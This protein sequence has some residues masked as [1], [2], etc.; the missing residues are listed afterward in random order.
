MG[1]PELPLSGSSGCEA[2]AERPRGRARK[3]AARVVSASRRTELLG[4]Y[5]DLFASRLE[6][7]GAE[8]V[9]SVVIWTKD[10]SNLLSHARLCRALAG[11]GQVF[12]HWTVTGL[13]GTFLESHVSP[14]EA[15]LALLPRVVDYVGDPR[16][17]HWRY[18]PLI[19]V[20]RG[21]EAIT[22]LD[23]DRFRALA[24]DFAR[25]G[26]PAVHTSFL[27]PYPKVTRRLEAAGV[28]L[29][30][31]GADEQLAFLGQVSQEAQDLGLELITCA[32]PGFP[33]R[34]CIDGE[35][36]TAL[37]PAGMACRTDRARGQRELCGCT[38]SLDLGRYLPCPNRCLYCYARP[39]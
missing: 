37:H 26:V 17:I 36:L 32:Q 7:V 24:R 38:A 21:S 25:A 3:Q 10:P 1:T 15:Q 35:L 14:P 11:V 16:R 33:R 2:S 6:E 5:P 30:R 13:G 29:E 28:R 27:T 4:H 39:A 18:D 22:N 12:L 19:Q 9:H 34:R 31:P 23:L 20:T 8:R